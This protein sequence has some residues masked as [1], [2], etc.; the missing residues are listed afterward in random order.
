MDKSN[1]VFMWGYPLDKKRPHLVTWIMFVNKTG[2]VVWELSTLDPKTKR[3]WQLG[4][5][6]INEKDEL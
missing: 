5:G 2:M 6:L 1:R 4:W 3:M